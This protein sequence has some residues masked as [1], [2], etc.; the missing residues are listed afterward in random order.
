MRYQIEFL[1]RPADEDSVC[2]TRAPE[3]YELRIAEFQAQAW[4]AQ[5]QAEHGARAWQSA[6][7]ERRAASSASSCSTAMSAACTK[8]SDLTCD[9]SIGMGLRAAFKVQKTL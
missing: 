3:A 8:A 2:L 6:T 7:C 4:S 9:P 5:A 1:R